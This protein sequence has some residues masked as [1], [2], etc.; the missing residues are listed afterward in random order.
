MVTDALS[1]QFDLMIAEAMDRLNRDLEATARLYK[2]LSYANIQLLTLT[3]GPISE[4]HVSIGGLMSELYLKNLADKTRRGLSGR[5]DAGK[6]AGGLSF[7]YD[8]VG[9]LNA[10]G[11][12]ITGELRINLNEAHIVEAILRRFASGDGPRAIARDLN[13]RG[14]PGPG[15]RKWGDTT[16][17]GH[18]KKGTGLI[19][20]ELYIGRRIWNRSKWIKNPDTGR[21]VQRLN[22][23]SDWKCREVPLL[24]I[25]EAATG[26]DRQ[27]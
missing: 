24:R 5:I 20:N 14:I 17:R 3:E 19:N 2:Q 13:Q 26:R 23:P 4:I 16:I 1:G 22:P 27:T 7:G 6:S 9:G 10:D 11:R 18:A 12:P 25:V 15:G 8:I 21:R